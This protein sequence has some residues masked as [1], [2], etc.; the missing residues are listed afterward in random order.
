MCSV[1]LH[2]EWIDSQ[3]GSKLTDGRSTTKKRHGS[4]EVAS[5]RSARRPPC[6]SPLKSCSA[7][8]EFLRDETLV[9]GGCGSALLVCLFTLQNLQIYGVC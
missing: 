7:L 9:V 2:V 5:L 6:L 3:S 8:Q 1:N 4:S